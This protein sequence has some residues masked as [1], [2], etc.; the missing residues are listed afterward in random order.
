M[1]NA[2]LA[3]K[4]RIEKNSIKHQLDHQIKALA[5][6]V[7][8]AQKSLDKNELLNENMIVNAGCISGLIARW[9]ML[10]DYTPYVEED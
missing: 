9:N 8:R 1:G 7:A 6:E 10:L 2:R 3:S 4:F 5:V